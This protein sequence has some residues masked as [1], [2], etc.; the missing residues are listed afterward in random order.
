[1]RIENHIE[2]NHRRQKLSV[3]KSNERVNKSN[4]LRFDL[5]S[6]IFNSLVLMGQKLILI[7]WQCKVDLHR[8][9]IL[10]KLYLDYVYFSFLNLEYASYFIYILYVENFFF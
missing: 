8:Q 7:G 4:Y 5:D 6:S 3:P 1:M 9:S 10:I 2:Q